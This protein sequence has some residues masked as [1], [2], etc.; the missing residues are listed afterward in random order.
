M[1]CIFR[2]SFFIYLNIS[3]KSAHDIWH[4]PKKIS[5][6]IITTMINTVKPE[7]F[8]HNLLALYPEH[9]HYYLQLASGIP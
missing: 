8:P 5:I 2:Y 1:R 4:N 7:F 6:V 9:I 3:L